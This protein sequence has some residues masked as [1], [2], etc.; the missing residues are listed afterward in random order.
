M[1]FVRCDIALI[2]IPTQKAK[3]MTGLTLTPVICDDFD[4]ATSI[5]KAIYKPDFD[6][7]IRSAGFDLAMYTKSQ[8]H[9]WT[10]NLTLTPVRCDSHL[11]MATSTDVKS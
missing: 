2:L 7:C 1:T 8:S 10:I 9:V 6:T 3:V 4:L 11:Y 5:A